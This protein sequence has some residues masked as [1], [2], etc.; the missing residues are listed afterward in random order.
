MEGK[1]MYSKGL[2]FFQV[3][4]EDSELNIMFYANTQMKETSRQF[5]EHILNDAK[6]CLN[7]QDASGS[8]YGK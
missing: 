4:A 6:Y 3:S 2:L 5:P 1:N 8:F 7:Q